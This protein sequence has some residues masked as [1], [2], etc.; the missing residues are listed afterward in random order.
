MRRYSLSILLPML[1]AFLLYLIYRPDTTVLNVMFDGLLD[2]SFSR[3][4][5]ELQ[6]SAPL[7][8]VL[9]NCLP[10]GLWLF[11]A[12]LVAR[13][14]FIRTA[15]RKVPLVLM[16]LAFAFLLEFCQLGGLTDGTFDALDL[17]SASI[18]AAAAFLFSK[19]Y[20]DQERLQKHVPVNLSLMA[21][22]FASVYLADV[23][24]KA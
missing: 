3:W 7:P 6:Q 17:T 5:L 15:D 22:L 14:L 21:V 23:L 8:S 20:L 10:E 1:L 11:S 2:S 16:P 13:Q 9:F 12:T 24:T 4:R 18:G 19:R